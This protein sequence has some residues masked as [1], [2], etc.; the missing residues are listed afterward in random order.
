M[1]TSAASMF[2]DEGL[3]LSQR[4]NES[5]FAGPELDPDGEEVIIGK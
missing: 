5:I 3:D 4:V 2:S 1:E